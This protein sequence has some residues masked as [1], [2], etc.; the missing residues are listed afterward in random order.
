MYEDRIYE[1]DMQLH[2]EYAENTGEM[3]NRR[4]IVHED[5]YEGMNDEEEEKI[6]NEE[7]FNYSLD[8]K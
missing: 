3:V 2:L 8:T 4:R 7:L 5:V 6:C 1:A